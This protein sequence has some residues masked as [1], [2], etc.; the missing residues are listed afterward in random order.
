M[1]HVRKDEKDFKY[2][3]HTLLEHNDK[4]K[5]IAFVGGDRDMAQQ[6]FP[7]PLTRCTFFHCKKHVEDDISRK[8]DDLRLKDIKNEVLLDIFESDKCKEKGI[9]DS[10]DEEEFIA[11]GDSLVEKW[12]SMEKVIFPERTPR[13]ADYFPAHIEE[14]MKDGMLLSTR[15]KPGLK[16]KLQQFQVQI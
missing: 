11:K 10:L 13:F 6:S 15:R 4:I 2:F 3:S 16:D 12:K 9:V 1:L 8:I 14:D 5:R 7:S